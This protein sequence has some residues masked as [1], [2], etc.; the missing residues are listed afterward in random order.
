MIAEA[1]IYSVAEKNP[2]KISKNL[3]D[4]SLIPRDLRREPCCKNGSQNEVSDELSKTK[5]LV[6]FMFL[7]K[8]NH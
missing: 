5:L 8:I 3:R 1:L 7:S 6:T 2:A 4:G